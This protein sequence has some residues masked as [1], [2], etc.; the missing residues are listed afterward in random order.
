MA[1]HENEISGTT[2]VAE[3]PEFADRTPPSGRR[4]ERDRLVHRGL[5]PRRAEDPAREERIP[6]IR[7]ENARYD[8]LYQV[9]TFAEVVRLAPRKR[10]AAA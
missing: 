10:A 8:G 3:H 9:P 2:D 4:R 1:R 7:P 6:A 5:H